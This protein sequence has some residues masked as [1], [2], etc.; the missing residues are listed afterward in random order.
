MSFS[1]HYFVCFFC[2]FL[3]VCCCFFTSDCVLNQPRCQSGFEVAFLCVCASTLE[4]KELTNLT[5]F[6]SEVGERVR[7]DEP[8]MSE[9][10][11]VGWIMHSVAGWISGC[12]G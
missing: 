4:R 2:L 8:M 11:A 12:E 9:T 5:L 7:G 1:W 10:G 3:S 6:P